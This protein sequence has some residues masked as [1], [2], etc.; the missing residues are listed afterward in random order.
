MFN[1][2]MPYIWRFKDVYWGL[3]MN[4]LERIDEKATTKSYCVEE[5]EEKIE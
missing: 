5:L 4:T 3:L 2:V 1:G